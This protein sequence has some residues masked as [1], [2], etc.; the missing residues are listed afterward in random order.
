MVFWGKT[1]K[2]RPFWG[3]K[4]D[5]QFIMNDEVALTMIVPKELDMSVLVDTRVIVAHFAFHDTGQR[6]DVLKTDLLDRYRALAKERTCP[7]D[8]S[9]YTSRSNGTDG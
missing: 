6:E 1:M 7:K 2:K 9:K 5:P 8:L 3:E 4:G